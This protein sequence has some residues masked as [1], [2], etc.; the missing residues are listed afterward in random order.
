M[1]TYLRLSICLF[2]AQLNW[3]LFALKTSVLSNVPSSKFI[4]LNSRGRKVPEEH[5]ILQNSKSSQAHLVVEQKNIKEVLPDQ[6]V[7]PFPMQTK[8]GCFTKEV[9]THTEQVTQICLHLFRLIICLERST[10]G[11]SILAFLSL[12]QFAG[13]WQRTDRMPFALFKQKNPYATSFH[14]M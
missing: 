6:P 11:Q 5:K 14:I 4:H 3:E 12:M 7:I 8:G 10:I 9:R 2:N 13:R 1:S